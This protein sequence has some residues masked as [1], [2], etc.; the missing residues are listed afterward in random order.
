MGCHWKESYIIC[1]RLVVLNG[2]PSVQYSF[3]YNYDCIRV[4]CAHPRTSSKENLCHPR[5]TKVFNMMTAQ[6]K[7]SNCVVRTTRPGAAAKEDGISKWP[8]N[9]TLASHVSH[10]CSTFLH[11]LPNIFPTTGFPC[12]ELGCQVLEPCRSGPKQWQTSGTTATRP[13]LPR[14]K[15]SHL[16]SWKFPSPDSPSWMPK[17]HLHGLQEVF[18]FAEGKGC[19]LLA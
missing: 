4:R 13:P 18:S 7:A 10:T 6:M 1:H 19:F 12:A 5:F 16:S 15:R 8:L 17:W 3:I 2:D 11:C 14:G 9:G